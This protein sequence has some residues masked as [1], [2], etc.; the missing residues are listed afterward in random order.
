MD[1]S[2]V[3]CTHWKEHQKDVR[4][5]GREGTGISEKQ[6][7]IFATELWYYA[8]LIVYNKTLACYNPFSYFLSA[9]Q[10]FT[11]TWS[12]AAAFSSLVQCPISIILLCLYREHCFVPSDVL[13]ED[14]CHVTGTPFHAAVWDLASPLH[15]NW[16]VILGQALDRKLCWESVAAKVCVTL[17]PEVCPAAG[18]E[19]QSCFL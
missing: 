7:C 14:T 15:L 16:S 3:C 18:L 6:D 1:A 5:G 9:K 13:Q 17:F 19:I 10:W 12:W 8:S 11:K 2:L 4:S